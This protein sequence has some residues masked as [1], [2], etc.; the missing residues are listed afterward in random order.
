MLLLIFHTLADG[1][2]RSEIV[3]TQREHD[4]SYTVQAEN[5]NDAISHQYTMEHVTCSV[6]LLC[7]LICVISDS[8]LA[9]AFLSSVSP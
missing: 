2:S 9:V 7:C 3:G 5:N 8:T 6:S 1:I 4:Y